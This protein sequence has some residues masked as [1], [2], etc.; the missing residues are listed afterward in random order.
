[1]KV[2]RYPYDL[3]VYVMESSTYDEKTGTYTTTQE[4]WEFY[5][6]CR[7]QP[8]SSNNTLTV[9]G[10]VF[11]YSSLVFAP[12]NDTILEPGTKVRVIESDGTERATGKVLRMSKDFF[13]NRIWLI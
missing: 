10:E 4:G 6:N 5:S 8:Q 9:D 2:Q 13:H 11:Q 7:D 12:L 3:E 1:M